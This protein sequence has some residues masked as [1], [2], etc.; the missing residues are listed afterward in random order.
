MRLASL[1]LQLDSTPK[2]VTACLTHVYIASSLAPMSEVFEKQESTL[3]ETKL[4]LFEPH[5]TYNPVPESDFLF[6][7]CPPGLGTH[8]GG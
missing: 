2:G 4:Q 8:T 5:D 3:V 7:A 6:C 1:L